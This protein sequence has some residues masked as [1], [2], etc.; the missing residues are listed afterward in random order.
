MRLDPDYYRVL[1]VEPDAPPALI[2]ASFRT[3]MQRLRNAP[4]R[5][6]HEQ[7]ALLT[8]AYAVLSDRGRR[9]AYD[10]ARDVA[11]SGR[12]ADFAATAVLS[13]RD[14]DFAATAVLAPC[15]AD[16]AATAV[17]DPDAAR[18]AAHSCPFCG[19]THGLDRAIERED[20]CGERASPLNPVQR[21]RLEPS[22]KRMPR[23][24]AKTRS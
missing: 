22:G 19:T 12:A 23:R 4:R 15:G 5:G 9:A 8:E 18:H 17:L 14:A 6:T 3:L 21:Q 24:S 1:L 2:H 7:A 16:F 10:L 20:G 11:C 13:H